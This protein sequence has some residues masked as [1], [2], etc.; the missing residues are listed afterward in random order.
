MVIQYL[1]FCTEDFFFF[2]RVLIVI[3]Y[4]HFTQDT[5]LS[6][7]KLKEALVISNETLFCS[8]Q[9]AV[10]RK[11]AKN[12]STC[13]KLRTSPRQSNKLP[14]CSNGDVYFN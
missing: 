3:V 6:K 11:A 5:C 2:L 1:I 13:V 7:Q 8:L 9:D 10:G 12:L 4:L 14:Q